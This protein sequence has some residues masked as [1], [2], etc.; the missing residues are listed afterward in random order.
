MLAASIDEYRRNRLMP[1]EGAIPHLR[2]LDM[3]GCSI[4]A[5]TGGGDLYEYINFLQRDDRDAR[6]ERCRK[7]SRE[8]LAPHAPGAPDHNSVDELMEWLGARP[9]FT[10]EMEAGY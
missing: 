10:P 7:F 4:P 3:Y 9:E 2:G 5:G 6:I 1:V 8:F